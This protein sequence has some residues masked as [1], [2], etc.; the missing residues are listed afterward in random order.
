MSLVDI[1]VNVLEKPTGMASALMVELNDHLN[2]LISSGETHVIDLLSL[3]LN[4]AD[5]NEL[6]DLLG[7]GEVKATISSIGS[8]SIRETA[9]SGIWW[10]THYGDDE[11]VLSEL[12]E[13]TQVPQILITHM[14]EV[15]HSAQVLSGSLSGQENV[16]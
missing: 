10:I 6:A 14:D 5:I 13:V 7:V 2:N 4:E 11:K 12:I 8:S 9:Y 15:R 16:I 3:P 1:P